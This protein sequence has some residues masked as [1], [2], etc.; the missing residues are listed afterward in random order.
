MLSSYKQKIAYTYYFITLRIFIGRGVEWI[1][2]LLIFSGQLYINR[3]IQFWRLIETQDPEVF[4]AVW[5]LI[6]IQKPESISGLSLFLRRRRCRSRRSTH[7]DE[8]GVLGEVTL[9]K[10]NVKQNDVS[11]PLRIL[12]SS[13]LQVKLYLKTFVVKGKMVTLLKINIFGT[14]FFLYQIFTVNGKNWEMLFEALKRKNTKY[15]VKSLEILA[16]WIRC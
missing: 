12:S 9:K 11:S 7:L 3:K 15:I 14:A 4:S 6:E 8:V 10:K 13:L 2:I 1:C 16:G 5:C